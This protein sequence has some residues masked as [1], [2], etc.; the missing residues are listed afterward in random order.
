MYEKTEERR[1]RLKISDAKRVAEMTK[2]VLPVLARG[3]ENQLIKSEDPQERTLKLVKAEAKEANKMYNEA[4]LSHKAVM[5]Q[6]EDL[7]VPSR[8][9]KKKWYDL[10]I[11]LAAEKK[12]MGGCVTKKQIKKMKDEHKP[13][14]D[15]SL[16]DLE[17]RL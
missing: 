10:K 7:L 12:A 2:Q 5:K 13:L 8:R 16:N 17:K 6:A 9:N 1:E 11:K 4:V 3:V 15:A 14:E